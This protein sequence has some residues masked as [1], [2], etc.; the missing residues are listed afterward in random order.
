[1][2]IREK[3]IVEVKRNPALY[4]KANEDYKKYELRVQIWT[5]IGRKFGLSASEAQSKWKNL[6]DNM[7]KH[8]KRKLMHQD[9]QRK[10]KQYAFAK[11][12]DFIVPFLELNGRPNDTADNTSGLNLDCEEV[13]DNSYAAEEDGSISPAEVP[14]PKEETTH[15]VVITPNQVVQSHSRSQS[16][17]P[18]SS[19]SNS[20][21]SPRPKRQRRCVPSKQDGD[22]VGLFLASMAGSI[23]KLPPEVQAQVRFSIHRIVHDAEMEYLYPR[24]KEDKH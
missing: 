14:I 23:R 19:F 6:R 24:M 11:L 12:L 2:D 5:A 15:P 10:V 9:G 20:A 1:M 17:S 16:S 8:M 4:D 13:A 21:W 3:L 7:V 22:E 18:S